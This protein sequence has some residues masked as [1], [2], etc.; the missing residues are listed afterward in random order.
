MVTTAIQ[1]TDDEQTALLAIA[2]Q[3][4]KSQAEL[5]REAVA[6]YLAKFDSGSRRHLLQQA[7]GMWKDRTDLP[8]PAELRGEMD[9]REN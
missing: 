5:L 6:Q 7:R 3:T 4:G 2:S 1:L 8:S 9:R